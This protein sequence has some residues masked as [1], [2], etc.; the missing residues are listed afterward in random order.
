MIELATAMVVIPAYDEADNTQT[1]IVAMP[2]VR[3]Q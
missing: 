2:D 3:R 1:V